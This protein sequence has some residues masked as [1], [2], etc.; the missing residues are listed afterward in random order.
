M[1]M[2]LVP[3]MSSLSSRRAKFKMNKKKQA[4]WEFHWQADNRARRSQGLP[5]ITFEQY[6]EARLGKIKLPQPGFK[7]LSQPTSTHPRYVDR[8]H[9][10]SLNSDLGNTDLK[11]I[12]KYTGN[13]IIGIAVLHKSCLQPVTSPEAAREVARMRRN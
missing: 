13:E 8:Q 11:T 9:V 10:P 2:H 5:K 12:P 7:T 3:G 1:T 4:E 6:C